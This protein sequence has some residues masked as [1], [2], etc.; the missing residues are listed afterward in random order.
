MVTR[1]LPGEI[2][3]GELNYC[4]TQQWREKAEQFPVI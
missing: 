3:S 1:K 4:I 2:I